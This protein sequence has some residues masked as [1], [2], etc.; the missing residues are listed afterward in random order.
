MK[1]VGQPLLGSIKGRTMQT[2]KQEKKMKV[3]MAGMTV[4]HGIDRLFLERTRR[5]SKDY[6]L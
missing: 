1:M 4:Q 2:K 3:S 6:Y 5:K